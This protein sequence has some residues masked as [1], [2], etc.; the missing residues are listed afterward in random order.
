MSTPLFSWL[1]E[2][3]SGVLLHPTSLPG[4]QGIGTL[5]YSAKSF[6]QFLADANIRF[7]QVCP[8][9]PTG[10]GDSPYQTFSAFA[11][12][13]YLIDFKA[14]VG[15][16]LL[17]EQDL[18]TLRFL[19]E[20]KVEYGLLW[21]TK[22]P[23][24]FKAYDNFL[25]NPKQHSEVKKELAAFEK[26]NSSWLEGFSLFMALKNR[27]GGR[28]WTEW[29]EEFRSFELAQK[30]KLTA[31]D[32]HKSGAHRFFQYLFY[33]QWNA[34]KQFANDQGVEIIGDI[35]IFVA[36]DSADVWSSPEIFQLDKSSLM[37]TR[38]A[39]CPP[40]YFSEDGQFWGNPLYD[41]KQLKS[42]G[43]RWWLDRFKASFELYDVIRID[44][45]RGFESYWSI[46][47]DAETASEGKWVKGPGIDFF[48]AVKKSFPKARIIAEDLG[49]ITP[50]V[51]ELLEGT[52]L[53]GMAVLQF[54][55]GMGND[56]FYLPHNIKRNSVVYSGTHDN[57]TSLGWYES[58]DEQTQDH[59]R[60]YF[61]VSGEFAGWDLMRAA[62]RSVANLAVVPMQDLLSLGNEA[63]M[64]RPGFALG[65]W[66]WRYHTWQLESLRN[67][68]LEYLRYLADL[69]RREAKAGKAKD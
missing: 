66:Q 4:D 52:G 37:P 36:L 58:A 13:P 8:L 23:I 56:N 7:W 15:M 45:F 22:W 27:F 67:E 21:E 63:R 60:K 33:R 24:L 68:S 29:S 39:G 46:P 3:A 30:Q 26:K 49:L 28:S 43:Y 35:P 1:Q 59:F 62:Y 65:N 16:K 32:Q 55:F 14:L 20:S 42:D 57:D 61:D 11:G 64:N 54:A 2:R 5:D 18:N 31:E 44:H 25:A 10:F 51:I 69:Y 6:V 34:L 41:W 48:K 40:D 38:V 12:N 9:G 19:S 50:E 47:A 53:P 17:E